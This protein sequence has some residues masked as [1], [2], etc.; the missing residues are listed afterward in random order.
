MPADPVLIPTPNDP[1]V[2]LYQRLAALDARVFSIENRQPFSASNAAQVSGYSNTW[3]DLGGPGLTLSCQPYQVFAVMI[4]AD[5]QI[6]AGG[7]SA[8]MMVSVTGGGGSIDVGGAP[9]SFTSFASAGVAMSTGTSITFYMLYTGGNVA[10]SQPAFWQNRII[11][12]VP[13][14]G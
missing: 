1:T 11:T 5:M 4:Q 13:I 9:V 2:R 8:S 10:T 7:G 6:S 12:V 3:M 14:S